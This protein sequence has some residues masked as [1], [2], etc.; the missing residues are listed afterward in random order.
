[1]QPCMHVRLLVGLVCWLLALFVVFFWRRLV[2]YLFVALMFG[3]FVVLLFSLFVVW[4][5]CY[6][7]LG[8]VV[9]TLSCHLFG[10]LVDW[11]FVGCI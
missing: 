10:W 7:S 2:H 4:L 3:C 6:L 9:V 8:F 11:W 5:L 1:M